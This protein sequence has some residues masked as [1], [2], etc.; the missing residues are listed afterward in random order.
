MKQGRLGIERRQDVMVELGDHWLGLAVSPTS[1]ALQAQLNLRAGEGLVVENVAPD[2]PAAKAGVQRFDVLLKAGD[3]QLKDIRDLVGEVNKVKE[4]KLKIELIR[5]GKSQTVTAAPA[6]RPRENI[7]YMQF[8]MPRGADREKI[9]AWIR[10]MT[11]QFDEGKPLQFHFFHPGQILPPGAALPKGTNA[12]TKATVK[13]EM[14][15][16]DGYKMEIVRED[17]SPAKITV[18]RGKEKW[19]ATEGDLSKLP[20]KLRPEVEKFLHNGPFGVSVWASSIGAA[21]PIEIRTAPFHE[22]RPWSHDPRLDKR[23]DEMGRLLEKLRK[24]VEELRKATPQK[25]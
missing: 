20:E 10:E 23:L 24:D 13:A 7:G 4:G 14:T 8:P 5:G 19:D 25:K 16:P 22:V 12:M 15:L 3:T 21:S 6:V 18:T 2:G 9:E 17:G 1:E 11:P